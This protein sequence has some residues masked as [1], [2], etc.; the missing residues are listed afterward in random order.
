MIPFDSGMD[1]QCEDQFDSEFE[2]LIKEID[3]MNTS[4]DLPDDLKLNEIIEKMKT[5]EVFTLF[6]DK[7]NSII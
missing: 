4:T 6:Q 2:Q 1:A 5:H 3:T 7:V